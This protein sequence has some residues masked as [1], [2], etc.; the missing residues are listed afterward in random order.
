MAKS[1]QQPYSDADY[2]YYEH[3][4]RGVQ[5]EQTL[6]YVRQRRT[7]INIAPHD[8]ARQHAKLY[9]PCMSLLYAIELLQQLSGA[10]TTGVQDLC[11]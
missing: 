2:S 9:K 11:T 4:Q 8:F 10:H 1:G 3:V 7:Q 6:T 5:E